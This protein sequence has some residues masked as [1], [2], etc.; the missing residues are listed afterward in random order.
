ME[1][2]TIRVGVCGPYVGGSS[3]M[4]TSMRDGA[5]LAVDEINAAGG[6]LGRPLEPLVRDDEANVEKANAIAQSLIAD[7]V[8]ATVG[9]INTDPAL[10]ATRYYQQAQVPVIVS[11]TAGIGIAQQFGGP[12]HPRN[13]IFR[14][15]MDDGVIAACIAEQ[16]FERLLLKRPA[17]FAA[18]AYY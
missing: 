9:F 15:S 7:G 1:R 5:L 17:I 12:E 6:V 3:A 10:S 13:Y 18:T 4:G 2:E 11:C 14:V 8:A 16:V